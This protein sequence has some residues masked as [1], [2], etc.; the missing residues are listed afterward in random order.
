V[1]TLR[2]IGFNTLN[3]SCALFYVTPYSHVQNNCE[4]LRK[5]EI[6]KRGR[7]KKPKKQAFMI[8]TPRKKGSWSKA[9]E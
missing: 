3:I 4:A 9:T 5:G 2:S 1:R 7:K 6:H 8:K